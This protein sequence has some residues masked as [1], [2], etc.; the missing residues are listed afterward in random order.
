MCCEQGH[1]DAGKQKGGGPAWGANQ[2]FFFFAFDT[3]FILLQG[4][5]QSREIVYKLTTSS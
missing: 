1:L 2:F 3:I 4:V 5:S